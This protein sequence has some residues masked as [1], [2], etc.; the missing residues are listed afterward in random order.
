[1]VALAEAGQVDDRLADRLGWD[2]ARVD[3]HAS[4]R[5]FALGEAHA[6]AQLRCLDSGLLAPRPRADHEQIEVQIHLPS[7]WRPGPWRSECNPP[8]AISTGAR[9]SLHQMDRVRIRRAPAWRWIRPER[10][11]GWMSTRR[12][13][14]SC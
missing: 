7:H 14:Q 13:P 8:Q 6:A 12:P 9:E 2:R 4:Q 3:A 1:H 10:G 5:A 11:A